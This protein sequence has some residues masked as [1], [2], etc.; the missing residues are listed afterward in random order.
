MNDCYYD[1]EDLGSG[2]AGSSY[3]CDVNRRRL[4]FREAAAAAAGG[5]NNPFSTPIRNHEEEED[6]DN[7][8]SHGTPLKEWA[9][10]LNRRGID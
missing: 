9:S 4:K 6:G 2:G 3:P 1:E 5:H 10:N 7:A 8:E